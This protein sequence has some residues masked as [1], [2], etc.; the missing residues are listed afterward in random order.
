MLLGNKVPRLVLDE[1]ERCDV[2]S[3]T[4]WKHLFMSLATPSGDTHNFPGVP[5]QRLSLQPCVYPP[6]Q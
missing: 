3:A 6:R 5:R 4:D 2:S 1:Q